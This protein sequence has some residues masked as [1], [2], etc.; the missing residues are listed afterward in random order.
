MKYLQRIALYLF[1]FSINF[2]VW[3]PFQTNALFSISKITGYIYVLTMI[4]RIIKFSS[5]FDLKPILK[6]IWLFFGLLT[7][8]SIF[9]INSI[10]YNFFDFRMFQ[11]IILFYILIN[12]ERC[13]PLVLGKGM[14][15]YSL[16]SVVLAILFNAGIGI[17][18]DASGRITIFNDNANEV[19]IRMCISMIIIILT[20]LQN[21]LHL[22][23]IRYLLLLPLP[24]MMALMAGTGSRVA[25]ISL[26]L[27]FITGVT[28]LKTKKVLGKILV[29]AGGGIVF[30]FI[31]EFLMQNEV[32]INRLLQSY[33]EGDLANRGNIWQGLLP[34]VKSNPFFGVGITGYIPFVQATFGE[35]VSPHNVILEVLCYT[36]VVGL[37][38]FLIF[39]YIIFNR[40]YQKYKTEGLLLP[41]ILLIPVLGLI[42]SGQ[43]L[44]TK[45]GWIIFSYAAS[46]QILNQNIERNSILNDI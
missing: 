26:L 33:Q 39:L 32:L 2:E 4:P 20:I 11:N 45:I 29:F 22:G 36:G 7:L 25:V 42:A 35:V 40:S 24:I 28:L 21:R 6:I 3:D 31:W 13:D 46:L 1:F 37:T 18:I 19:A 15:S 30:V 12:H 44:Y 38:I 14:L 17:Q 10:N 16:G 5:D 23:K 41:L 27:A 8:V 9:N 43:I 34:L